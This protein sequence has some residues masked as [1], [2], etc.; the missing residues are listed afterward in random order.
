MKYIVMLGDGMAD[1][2]IG[3]LGGQTPLE[4]AHKPH[5]DFLAQH[6]AVGMARTI[7]EG[8]PPGSDAA[9]MSVLGYPPALY[10]TGRSPLE[11]V[12]M[13]IDMAPSD[14]AI[15]CN[16]AC[17]SDEDDY[18]DKTMLDYSSG[19]IETEEARELLLFLA[20][21]FNGDGLF[22]YPGIS[23]RHCLLLKNAGTGTEL[24]PPH[25][26]T[27]KPVRDYLP[28]GR[29]GERLYALMRESHALLKEH[30]INKARVARGE[31]P[32][33]TCWFWGEG[34]KPAF[35]PF[36]EIYGKK[37]AVVCAVDLI[38]GLGL[39]AG[40][41]VPFVE[42]ATGAK[43][44][45]FAAKGRAALRLLTQEGYE[46][47]YI[48]VEAPDESGHAGDIPCKVE[49]IERIDKELL[50]PLMEGLRASGEDFALLL[51]PDHPTP[52]ALRTHTAEPIPFVLYRSDRGRGPST[53]RYTEAEAQKTGLFLPEGPMLMQ[54]LVGLDF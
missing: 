40:M 50:G 20:E 3:A 42:G 26:I 18:A 29:Y 19:E 4:A 49:S 44:T 27:G 10:Y 33:N 2:P 13:G 21:R 30:P 7:P 6:G 15:R 32:A 47:V 11:A 53:A 28:K 46:L 35:K 52:I 25:D 37:A 51:A 17:V 36:S 41:H 12:S 48:H 54:K 24:T 23:Y 45:D 22:L 16:L 14:L 8:M 39:C 9:N 34:T 31:L 43:R 1:D 38:K 5:M